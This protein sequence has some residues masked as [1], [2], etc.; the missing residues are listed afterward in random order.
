[1]AIFKFGDSTSTVFH[2]GK[3]LQIKILFISI[4]GER[5]GLKAEQ[6]VNNTK[7]II[8]ALYYNQFSIHI[9]I[10][11]I[12][13]IPVLLHRAFGANKTNFN[14]ISFHFNIRGK[15]SIIPWDNNYYQTA[16]GRFSF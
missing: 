10:Q 6:Y 8:I 9:K 4:S 1:M 5:R 15:L 12:I 11:I 7:K 14:L 2:F 16:L 13:V 3:L